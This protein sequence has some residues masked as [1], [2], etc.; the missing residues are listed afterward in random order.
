[1]THRT[2]KH[3]EGARA[4]VGP[5]Q[6]GQKHYQ[7]AV[8]LQSEGCVSR[9][10]S[11]RF[12]L[13]HARVRAPT[14]LLGTYYCVLLHTAYYYS[15][16]RVSTHLVEPDLCVHDR[17][18]EQRRQHAHRQHVADDHLRQGVDEG[19]VE[20]VGPLAREDLP[21]SDEDTDG[22]HAKQ[23]EEEDDEIEEK[24]TR[25]VVVCVRSCGWGRWGRCASMYEGECGQ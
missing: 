16:I 25:L 13:V 14:L 5:H 7:S 1:M 6:H 9:V 18:E 20:A 21:L 3:A 23:G 4:Q 10:S 11:L 12:M 2:E 22:A 19:V 17:A 15:C 24:H 8:L